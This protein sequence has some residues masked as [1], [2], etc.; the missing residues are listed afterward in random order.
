V[1]PMRERMLWIAGGLV[2]LL[3]AGALAL[4]TSGLTQPPVGL[5]DE[6][7]SAGEALAPREASRT[8]PA[9]P[10]AP[11]RTTATTPP[12]RT[13]TAPAPATTTDDHGGGTDDSGGHGRG[14]GRGSDDGGADDD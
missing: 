10:A 2:G 6:P 4:V 7:V 12:A 5:A 14:R 8:A 1:R 9:A 11:A 13:T 3:L